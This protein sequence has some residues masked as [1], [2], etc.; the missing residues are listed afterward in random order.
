MGRSRLVSVRL[1]GAQGASGLAGA[2][3]S[4][5]NQETGTC[6]ACGE[7]GGF[8]PNEALSLAR[9]G[10]HPGMTL[11]GRGKP[12][13]MAFSRGGFTGTGGVSLEKVWGLPRPYQTASVSVGSA[14][15]RGQGTR[16]QSPRK[17]RRGIPLRSRD[18]VLRLRR[19]AGSRTLAVCRGVVTTQ[20]WLSRTM[21]LGRLRTAFWTIE[22]RAGRWWGGT[23]KVPE[24]R[25]IG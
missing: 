12:A 21:L 20:A 8:E 25:P 14:R 15:S 13:G 5:G 6:P 11:G 3:S 7:K 9:S 23:R 24:V 10:T 17:H 16:V 1:K 2:R 4:R 19:L 18:L 22:G